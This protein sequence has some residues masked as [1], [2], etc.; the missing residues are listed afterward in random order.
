[1]HSQKEDSELL[2]N[3]N[4]AQGHRYHWTT[5]AVTVVRLGIENVPLKYSESMIILDNLYI[6]VL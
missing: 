6:A 2:E 5:K 1:M 3:D 4:C